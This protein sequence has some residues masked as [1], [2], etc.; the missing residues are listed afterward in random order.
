MRKDKRSNDPSK[1]DYSTKKINKTVVLKKD[2]PVGESYSIRKG[3]KFL[4][5]TRPTNS[6]RV[7]RSP[8]FLDLRS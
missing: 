3:V 7:S 4:G 2:L 5:M 6:H 1:L 8:H